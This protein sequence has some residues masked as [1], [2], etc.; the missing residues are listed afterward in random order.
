MLWCNSQA[1]FFPQLAHICKSWQRKKDSKISE[2]LV[3]GKMLNHKDTAKMHKFGPSSPPSPVSQ[4]NR[5]STVNS[6]NTMVAQCAVYDQK[7]QTLRRGRGIRQK[8]RH[9]KEIIDT[10]RLKLGKRKIFSDHGSGRKTFAVLNLP[11][12]QHRPEP[13]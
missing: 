6:E 2:K 1:V 10:H 3:E 8:F 5:K 11:D 7:T 12:D 9:N 4:K 13:R